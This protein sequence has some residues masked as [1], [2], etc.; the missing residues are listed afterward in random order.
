MSGHWDSQPLTGPT[1]SYNWDDSV[2]L[3]IGH[4]SESNRLQ[5]QILKYLKKTQ[6]KQKRKKLS[7][8][9]E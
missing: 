1:N 4:W 8:L 2:M 3:H 9:I 7:S 6:E 5:G